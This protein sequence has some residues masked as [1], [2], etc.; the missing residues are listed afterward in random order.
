MKYLISLRGKEYEVEVEQG[1]AVLLSVNEASAAT[2]SPAFSAPAAPASPAPEPP[3]SA[4]GE[5]QASVASAPGEPIFA[6]LPGTVLSLKLEPGAKV[7]AGQVLLII[8][9]MKM[10]NEILAP[11]PGQIGAILCRSGETVQSGDLLLTLI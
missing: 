3:A 8:E 1:E 2:P 10:E 11:R 7:A 9:A 6:P 5:A 4:G